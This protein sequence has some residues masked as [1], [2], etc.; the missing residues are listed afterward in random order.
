M[1]ESRVVIVRVSDRLMS[2]LFGGHPMREVTSDWPDDAA[3]VDIWREDNRFGA[4][5]LVEVSS[6]TFDEVPEA[7]L[8]PEWTPTYTVTI[9]DDVLQ[10]FIDKVKARP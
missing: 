5:F 1:N 9:P 8:I 3:V 2:N 7:G 4:G 6:S 10:S